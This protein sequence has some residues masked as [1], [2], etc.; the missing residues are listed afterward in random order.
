MAASDQFGDFIAHTDGTATH[1]PTKLIWMRCAIGQTWQDSTCT[2]NAETYTW[3]DAKAFTAVFAG[4]TDWRLPNP[5][6]LASIVDYD[7]YYP[8]TNDTIFPFAPKDRFWSGTPYANHA[9][10]AWHVVISDGTVIGHFDR[11][12]RHHVRMVRGGPT[13]GNQTTPSTDF[14]DNGNGTVTH[15]KTGL[16][17]KRCAEGQAWNG[18]TC[19]GNAKVFT[20]AR[21][22][23]LSDDFGGHC[24]WR[25]PHIQELISI[26]EYGT[27]G[28]AV[29]TEIFPATPLSPAAWGFWSGT[30]HAYF[31]ASH[32]VAWGVFPNSGNTHNG[33]REAL[34]HVRLVRG[35]TQHAIS[36][37]TA[38]L[39]GHRCGNYSTTTAALAL[40][41]VD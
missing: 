16:T 17:W 40:P 19:A 30:P 7:Q 34:G 28:P 15:S 21:A 41:L 11:G 12:E 37:P 29:N 13:L 14:S 25:I 5:W 9:S 1:V 20:F 4:Q 6:E 39:Q 10:R 33:D 24:D 38:W 22:V 31:H 35:G 36:N 2:G 23:A 3:D 8:A 26:V 27:Y 18:T 32:G